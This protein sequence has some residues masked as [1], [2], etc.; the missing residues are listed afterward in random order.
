[1]LQDHAKIVRFLALAGEVTGRKKLQ[2]MIFIAK[3]MNYSFQEK[4]N[5]HIY[6]PYSEELTVRVEELCNLGFLT[7]VKENKGAYEQYCYT[8]TDA[9]LKFMTIV[10]EDQKDLQKLV[11]QMNQKSSRFL[12]LVSTLLYFEHLTELEQMKKVYTVKAKLKF[13]E[14]EMVDAFAF[15]KQLKIEGN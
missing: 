1:M 14:Q 3:K 15:I 10:Q 9:G 5:F 6:G 8:A 12:E 2:K 7:E 13:T 11:Q 4:Y